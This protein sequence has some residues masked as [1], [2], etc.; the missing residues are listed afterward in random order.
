[1]YDPIT[2]AVQRTFSRFQ[3]DCYSGKFRS[4]GKLFI[5]SDKTGQIKIL[6]VYTKSILRILKG[7][8]SGVRSCC[9]S[10]DNVHMFSGSDDASV[11]YWDLGTGSLLWENKTFHNDY[12]RSVD[13]SPI[14]ANL[15]ISGSYDHTIALWDIRM[16]HTSYNSISHNNDTNREKPVMSFDGHDQPISQCMFSPSGSLIIA[17]SGNQIKIWDITKGGM[18]INLLQILYIYLIALYSRLYTMTFAT[19]F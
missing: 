9:W 15:F 10:Q 4:D 3:D 16:K 12:I 11:K 14:N 2:D 13:S 19:I 1:M 17:A 18:N 5:A 6:D 8:T 7:H